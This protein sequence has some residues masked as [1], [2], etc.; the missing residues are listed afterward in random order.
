MPAL[1]RSTILNTESKAQQM[2]SLDHC[3]I[4][5]TYGS[6]GSG[7]DH[8]TAKKVDT[9]LAQNN[10]VINNAYAKG[11]GLEGD[12][13]IC[14]VINAPKAAENIYHQIRNTIPEESK[15]GY[16]SI[17]M[18]GKEKYQTQWPQ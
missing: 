11:F 12:I 5:L 1:A 8:K 3:T 6:Y 7:I 13:S 18:K 2:P 17:E 9:L 16:T 14:L 4:I 15:V 10:K